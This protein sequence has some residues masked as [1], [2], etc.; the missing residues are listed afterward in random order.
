[1]SKKSR[2]RVTFRSMLDRAASAT[3]LENGVA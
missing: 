2:S 1:M 3:S